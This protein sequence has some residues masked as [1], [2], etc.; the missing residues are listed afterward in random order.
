M[1]PERWNFSEGRLLALRRVA[2]DLKAGSVSVSLLLLNAFKE[3]REFS[4]PRPVMP[5][6][7][8][9]DAAASDEAGK[10]REP[11]NNSINVAA[12]SAVLLVADN[13]TI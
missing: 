5:W 10:P 2:A 1:T 6:R 4:L 13:V 8:L 7:L 3:D 12:H 9:I 11:R